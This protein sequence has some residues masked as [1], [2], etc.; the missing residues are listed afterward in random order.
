METILF[1]TNTARA[2]RTTLIGYLYEVSQSYRVILL[3][4][5]LDQQTLTVVND[6]SLFPGLEQIIQVDQYT[7]QRE[8][9]F[10]KNIRLV[11]LAKCAITT[12]TPNIVIASSDIHSQFEM[13]LIRRAKKFNILCITIQDTLSFDI[14]DIAIW[15]EMQSVK[16]RTPDKLPM[17]VRIA[18]TKIRKYLAFFLCHYLLPLSV[19]EMPFWGRYSFQLSNAY[20]GILNTDYQIVFD[21]AQLKLYQDG[22]VPARKLIVLAHP[23]KRKSRKIFEI[24]YFNHEKVV[25]CPSKSVLILLPFERTGV[26]KNGSSIIN[27]KNRDRLI[28]QIVTMICAKLPDWQI[29]IKPH[30]LHIR[31]DD[32]KSK[33]AVVSQ[34]IIVINPSDPVE[35]YIG[36]V[37]VIIDLPRSASTALFFASMQSQDKPILS[38]DLDHELL[39]DS[40]KYFRGVEYVDSMEQLST[41]IEQIR[42]SHYV[43]TTEVSCTTVEQMDLVTFLREWQVNVS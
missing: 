9:L 11:G 30:P 1:Y 7:L 27:Q 4:E 5:Q 31:N 28:L 39:G 38:L 19:A 21:A 14:K 37:D 29:Y 18:I 26:M 34:E 20:S 25:S 15:K 41:I 42:N 43:K 23:L 22:G 24:A 12:F 17:A 3:S 40:F 8:S 6:K 13:Y 10:R 36:M 2:F 33:I 32:I 16:T 35:S